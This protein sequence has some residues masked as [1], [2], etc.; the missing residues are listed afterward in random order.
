MDRDTAS[1]RSPSVGWRLAD[2][3]GVVSIAC[4]LKPSC[5]LAS[6]VVVVFWGVQ[7]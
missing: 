2:A 3:A 5:L 6:K 1:K 4:A 7:R